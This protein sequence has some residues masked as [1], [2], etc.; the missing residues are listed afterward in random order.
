MSA[1]GRLDR[2]GGLPPLLSFQCAELRRERTTRRIWTESMYSTGS[3]YPQLSWFVRPVPLLCSFAAVSA[4]SPNTA[5]RRVPRC[6]S[7]LTPG[8][9]LPPW[10]QLR[11]FALLV[12]SFLIRSCASASAPARSLLLMPAPLKCE[13]CEGDVALFIKAA[14]AGPADNA[15]LGVGVFFGEFCRCGLFHHPCGAS[16]E[17]GAMYLNGSRMPARALRALRTLTR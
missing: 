5:D 4:C 2:F 6:A 17:E 9:V 7:F 14:T 15:A 8:P 11:L 12:A 10:P 16:Q 1:G 13:M 3:C